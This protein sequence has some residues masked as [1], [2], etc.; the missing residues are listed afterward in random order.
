MTLLLTAAFV[1]HLHMHRLCTCIR[2]HNTCALNSYDPWA[3]L[4]LGSDATA[5]DVRRAFRKKAS[6]L[7]PDVSGN[8][9]VD[10]FRELVGAVE[11]IQNGM[12]SS[13]LRRPQY[14]SPPGMSSMARVQ[15]LIAQNRVVCFIRGT[16]QRPKCRASDYTVH[17]LS[18]AAFD[19]NTRFAAVDVEADPDLGVAVLE[20][21]DC[22]TLPLCYIDGE[23]IGGSD[24]L[25]QLAHSGEW[26]PRD[27]IEPR[28]LR[29]PRI[30][31]RLIQCSTYVCTG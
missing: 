26:A 3:I 29:R 16:K 15:W 9:S 30:H 23:L 4:G 12:T 17:L 10:L 18:T 2:H 31:S 6:K 20:H 22:S 28:C 13:S 25:Q 8:D 7:H 24:E 21:A 19:T 27:H 1:P 14:D 11:M 5:A